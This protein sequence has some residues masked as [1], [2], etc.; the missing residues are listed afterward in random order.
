MVGL[1]LIPALWPAAASFQ[2]HSLD[3]K[4]SRTDKLKQGTLVC[5]PWLWRG[6]KRLHSDKAVLNPGKL[7]SWGVPS[8]HGGQSA[9]KS[10]AATLPVLTKIN[11]MAV[12]T[13]TAKAIEQ[14][15]GGGAALQCEGIINTNIHSPGRTWCDCVPR[16]LLPEAWWMSVSPC[17]PP[18]L[19]PSLSY[20]LPQK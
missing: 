18:S 4:N 16:S 10:V 2:D 7:L 9:H 20:C 15:S 8:N 12:L 6:G 11:L 17:C 14:I 5:G 19:M 13:E 3:L 1:I